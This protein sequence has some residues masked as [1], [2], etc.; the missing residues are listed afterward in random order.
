MFGGRML[1]GVNPGSAEPLHVA[2]VSATKSG[3]N[4]FYFLQTPNVGAL[5]KYDLKEETE[6]SVFHREYFHGKDLDHHPTEPLLAF[7]GQFPNGTSNLMVMTSEGM[8]RLATRKPLS[9]PQATPVAAAAIRPSH[10]GAPP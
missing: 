6:R 2:V 7:V 8:L 5:C 9:S 10:H 4:L 1:W 3:Q